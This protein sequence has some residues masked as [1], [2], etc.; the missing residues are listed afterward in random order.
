RSKTDKKFAFVRFIR[1]DKLERLIENRCTI[2]IGR[3]RLHANAVRFQKEPKINVSQP[4][5]N[6]L[7]PNRTY[8][9]FV[10]NMGADSK[11]FASVLNAGRGN[12]SKAVDSSPTIVLDDECLVER[13]FSCSLI[14][15]IKDLNTLPNLYLILSNEGFDD[16]KLTHLGGLWVLLDMDSIATKEKVVMHVGVGS[17]FNELHQASNSFIHVKEQETWSPKFIK[18]KDEDSQSGYESDGEEEE[19][20]NGNLVNDSQSKN[21]NDLDE[22]ELDHVSESSCMHVND[23]EYNHAS[24]FTEHPINSDDPFE[25]YKILDKNNDKGGLEKNKDNVVSES[26]DPQF[27]LCFTPDVGQVNVD[28]AKSGRASQ[29]KEDLIG[30][31]EDVASV[32]SGIKGFKTLKSGGSLLD[33]IYELIKVGHVMGYNMDGCMKNIET[34]IVSQGDR[35]GTWIPSSTKILIISVYAPQE[36]T[37]KRILWDYLRH[38]IDTWDGECVLLRD[39]NEV[40]SIHERHDTMFNLL[41]ANSF[42]NFITMTGLVDLPLEGYSY[43][44]SNKFAS[45]MSKLDKFLISEGL[46]TLFPSLSALCLD[47]HLSDHCPILIREL[48]NSIPILKKKLQALKTSIKQWIKDDNICSNSTKLSIQNH[49]YAIDK[50]IDQGRCNE[51]LAIEGDENSKYFHGIINK[52]RSQ[53]AIR[54]VLV[55][56]DW[57]VE[58]SHLSDIERDVTYDEIK[59]AVWDCGTNKSPGPDG[60][61]FEFFRRYWKII[62]D[63]VVAA[64][65]QFFSSCTFPPWCN[66][67]FI[68]LIPKTQ[69]AK[70]DFEKAFDSVRWDY[71]DDVLNKFGFEVKWR[72]K[73]IGIGIPHEDVLLATD[74]IG[75]SIFTAPLIFMALKWVILCQDVALRRRPSLFTAISYV[76]LQMFMGVLKLLESIRRNF[77]NGVANSDKNLT[78]IGWKNILASKKN[79]GLGVSSF[80]ALNRALIFKWIWRFIPHDTSLWARFIKAIYGTKGALDISISLPS[81]CSPWLNILLGNGEGTSFWE[82]HWLSNLPLKHLNPRAFRLELEKHVTV[83]SKLRDMSLISSFRRASRGGTEEDQFRLLRAS[84]AHILLPQI[85]DSWVWNLESSCD[86]SVKSARSFIDDSLFPKADTPTRWVKVVPIKI[87]IFGWRVCLDKLPTSLNLSL[88]GIDV[89]SIL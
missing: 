21:E 76:H 89:P 87:N 66:S 72:S 68:A 67:S 17:W 33:V 55:E 26:T 78:L 45:N 64:V 31:N 44:W 57:I 42:N 88:R 58:P 18:L 35:Q 40:C 34:I 6:E 79:G 32:T 23:H 61:T 48:N 82:D 3:L 60:F 11:T 83:A 73:L 69:E 63:D 16:A 80:Y 14:G 86:F 19:N 54:G 5:T 56:G 49:L 30:T 29:P 25:I 70:V 84:V 71:L 39:F 1:V 81:R 50:S 47:R 46:L 10:K 77:F 38:M 51:F 22:N 4:K 28:E 7:Q 53:L 27:P 9:G 20:G 62:D 8:V 12:P 52:K 75:C 15:K 41:G 85:N 65:L 36:L 74:F 13:D 37:E 43:T 2:W 59:K 24:K